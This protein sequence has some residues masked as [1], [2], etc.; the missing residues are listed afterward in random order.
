[1]KRF[2]MPA[3]LFGAIVA[4]QGPI[5]DTG[6]TGAQGPAGLTGAT[7]P[8]GTDGQNEVG[9]LISYSST[10][11]VQLAGSVFYGQ[12]GANK[13]TVYSSSNCK[14][15]VEVLNETHPEFWLSNNQVALFFEPSGIRVL[16]VE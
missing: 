2:I 3:I 12:A 9:A 8:A 14:H 15:A 7:G 10:S 4:C 1:M 16:E 5:G 6:S 11:C 13:Y